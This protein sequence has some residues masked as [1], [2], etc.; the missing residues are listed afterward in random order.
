MKTWKATAC[1]AGTLVLASM[2]SGCWLLPVS[3][4]ETADGTVR[5][6]EV[7][8]EILIRLSGN[9]STG[10]QWIR[11]SPASLE[12]TPLE[13]VSEGE[14][15]LDDPDVCGGPGDFLFRYR[16]TTSGTVELLFEY[17]KPW[18]DEPTDTFSIILW[19]Q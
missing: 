5:S 15:E 7:G 17:R 13:A 2:L 9:V 11:Q 16:A 19:A 1:I 8:D 18:E 10:Q 3:I 6:V 12:G 14:Y 4:D